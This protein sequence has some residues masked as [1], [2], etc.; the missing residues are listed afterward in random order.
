[1]ADDITN[2]EIDDMWVECN[3]NHY[4]FAR[5]V[6]ARVE[7]R[8]RFPGIVPAEHIQYD[9]AGDRQQFQPSVVS[10]IRQSRGEPK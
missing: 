9:T 7:Q 4:R 3:K 10:L 6:V 2:E 5:L 1:M 8:E